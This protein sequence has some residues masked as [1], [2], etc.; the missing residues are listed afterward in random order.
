[1]RLVKDWR[2]CA[3]WFS[4]QAMFIA[5]AAQTTWLNLPQDM[6]D[7]IPV[8][9]LSVITVALMVLGII[10]RIIDQGGDEGA[11]E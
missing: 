7:S 9:W 11:G 8:K 5:G 2:E 6:K 4:M 3:K 1:M 10:G